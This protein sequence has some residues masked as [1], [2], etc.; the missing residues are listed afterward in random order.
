MLLCFMFLGCNFESEENLDKR[1][2]NTIVKYNFDGSLYAIPLGYHWLAYKRLGKW[3]TP[4]NE[5]ISVD[6]LEIFGLLP[7]LSPYSSITREKFD[8]RLGHGDIVEI[9]IQ[10]KNFAARGISE[11]LK[12]NESIVIDLK[13]PIVSGLKH[14]KDKQGYIDQKK[15]LDLYVLEEPKNINFWIVCRTSVPYPSCQAYEIKPNKYYLQYVFDAK[16]LS[17]W[18]DIKNKVDFI[19]NKFL[20]SD[21]KPL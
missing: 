18:K 7:D 8:S 17:E 6:A 10:K 4:K 1:L 20:V 5:Y 11:R 13:S 9:L 19:L 12:T 2:A 16:Y 14:Y 21:G 3:P 15:W